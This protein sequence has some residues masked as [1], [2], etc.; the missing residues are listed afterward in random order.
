M[1][2]KIIR[3]RLS[4]KEVPF[5]VTLLLAWSGW[6]IGHMVDR[7]IESPTVEYDITS[8]TQGAEK[9]TTVHLAN[10]SNQAFYDLKFEIQGEKAL[11]CQ[12]ALQN[13]QPAWPWNGGP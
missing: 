3:A 10:L 9:L 5:L 7:V 12:T 4:Q 11:P 2:W 8:V 6:G 1:S 13:V